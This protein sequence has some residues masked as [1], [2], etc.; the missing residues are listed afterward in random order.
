MILLALWSSLSV[1][2]ECV[3]VDVG[4]DSRVYIESFASHTIDIVC[5]RRQGGNTVLAREGAVA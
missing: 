3:G 1:Y 5:E 4:D 2:T